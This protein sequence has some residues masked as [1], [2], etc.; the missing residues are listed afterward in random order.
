MAVNLAEKYSSKVDEVMMN[1]ALSEAS[2]NKDYEFTGAKSV[3]VYSFDTVEMNDYNRSGSNRY[4]TPEELPDDTQEMILTQ[5]KSFTFTIDKGN[6]IDTPEGVRDAGKALR[7]Q[8]DQ[9]IKPMIDK[10]RFTKI[11]EGAEH[12]FFDTV[13]VSATTAYSLFLDANEAIDEADVPSEGRVANVSP[14]FLKELKKDESFIKAG[15]LSQKMLISGQV[16]E[17][18]G[19]AIVKV[20]S[21]RLP[22]GCLFE[23]THKAATVSPIKLAEYKIHQDPPG[24]SGQLAEGRVYFDAFVLSKKKNMIS[25]VYGNTGS[26]KLTATAGSSSTTSKVKVTG[27]TAGGTLVYKGDYASAAAAAAAIDVGDD[28]SS[29]TAFPANGVVTTANG[30]YIAV[31][32]KVNGKCVSGG[33]VAAVVGS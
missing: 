6:R 19:V 33:T 4:G 9:V 24:I 15:D 2:I 22:A 5:D 30:K 20:A 7:R 26:L 28:V 1:G 29:W 17:V 11:A 13:G 32:V 12:V 10:Y 3:K 8:V 31:A 18:D 25:V 16:G 21:S 27:N 14:K 23:I